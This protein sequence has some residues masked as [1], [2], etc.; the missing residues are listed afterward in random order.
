LQ[1]PDVLLLDEP[2]NHLDLD[3]IEWLE[4]YLKQQVGSDSTGAAPQISRGTR[5][6]TSA[7]VRD[8]LACGQ[9]L[10]GA[11]SAVCLISEQQLLQLTQLHLL[12]TEPCLLN[13]AA[14]T[15]PAQEVPMVIVSHDR[16][17][18]DNLCTKI[19]ETERGVASTYKGNYTAYVA[20]KAEREALQWAAYERQQKEI[21]KLQ[22]LIRRLSGGGVGGWCCAENLGR[23]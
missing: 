13:H 16:E 14:A 19:V 17:F 22:D 2:T 1:E 9:C 10:L 5:A 20:A 6:M 11:T 8:T 7:P 23:I 3:A 4:G 12:Y 18:L 21:E 15:T